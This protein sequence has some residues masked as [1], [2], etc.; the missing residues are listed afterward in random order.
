MLLFGHMLC[1]NFKE[2][3]KNSSR[4][5]L[6]KIAMLPINVIWSFKGYIRSSTKM[7]KVSM[8]VN[9]APYCSFHQGYYNTF[10][11]NRNTFF[12]QSQKCMFPLTSFMK[13]YLIINYEIHSIVQ[14]KLN[15]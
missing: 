7:E 11:M 13:M 9:E 4:G 1:E 8:I 10:Q 3:N 2:K 5:G 6:P 14:R 15:F 12:S